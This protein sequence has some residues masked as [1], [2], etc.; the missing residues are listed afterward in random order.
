MTLN[1]YAKRAVFIRMRLIHGVAIAVLLANAYFFSDSWGAWIQYFLAFVVLVHDIDENKFAMGAFDKIQHTADELAN[2]NSSLES[3]VA[4]RTK[5]LEKKN[6]DISKALE[7]LQSATDQLVQTEK[8]A[9]LGSLVAGMAHEVNTPLGIGV[10]AISLLEEGTTATHK[11]FLDG[12]VKRSDFEKFFVECKEST[13]IIFTNLNRAADL[14][15]SFKKIAVDQSHESTHGFNLADYLREIIISLTPNLKKRPIE[16]HIECPDNIDANTN[17]GAFAQVITN[18][19]MNSLLHAYELEEKGD[20]YISVTEEEGSIYLDYKDEGKGIAPENLSKVFDPFFT[21]KRGQGGS[22]L[23]MNIVY[24]IVNKNLN[25]NIKC[26]S[27]VGKGV[28]FSLDFPAIATV[29]T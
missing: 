4:K 3:Q 13:G 22:G 5:Q 27:E 25:G 21:T 10:T 15:Q 17:A 11:K 1:F 29:T 14:I 26:E 6:K 9:A 8:L 28:H 20:I 16:V 12:T 23:G 24:N 2:L 19:V 7:D 18:L